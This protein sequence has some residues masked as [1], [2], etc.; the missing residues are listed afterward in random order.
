MSLEEDALSDQEVASELWREEACED[1]QEDLDQHLMELERN[2][3]DISL[4]ALPTT[5]WEL[6][7]NHEHLPLD[8]AET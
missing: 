8:C 5:M 1:D 4:E 2:D 7:R 6:A 3:S